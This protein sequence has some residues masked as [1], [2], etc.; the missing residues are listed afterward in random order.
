MYI[1]I[2]SCSVFSGIFEWEKVIRTKVEMKICKTHWNAPILF[3][4][5]VC[6]VLSIHVSPTI[7]GYRRQLRSRS[8]PCDCA[9]QQTPADCANLRFSS[10]LSCRRY[11]PLHKNTALIVRPRRVA[12]EKN[13]SDSKQPQS[14]SRKNSKRTKMCI[15]YHYLIYNKRVRWVCV[16]ECV[17]IICVLRRAYQGRTHETVRREG[18][19]ARITLFRHKRREAHDRRKGEELL[20]GKMKTPS[21][22]V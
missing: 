16:C 2:V 7:A 15:K 1:F 10:E 3:E 11:W 22:Q 4:I 21:G 18:K 19:T 14:K 8:K 5:C 17:F 12:A 20:Y 9:A 6:S 13:T